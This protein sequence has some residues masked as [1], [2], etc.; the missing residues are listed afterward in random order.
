MDESVIELLF[1][2]A[3]AAQLTTGYGYARDFHEASDSKYPLVWFLPLNGSVSREAIN[4][5]VSYTVSGFVLEDAGKR[6]L[7]HVSR[8]I[9][10]NYLAFMRLLDYNNQKITIEGETFELIPEQFHDNAYGLQFSFT[11]SLYENIPCA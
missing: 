6:E 5:Y 7:S 11:L 3:K 10:D 8:S 1:R 9:M 4:P 2:A